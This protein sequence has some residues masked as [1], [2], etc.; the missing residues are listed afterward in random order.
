MLQQKKKMKP[1]AKVTTTEHYDANLNEIKRLSI[2][3]NLMNSRK[4]RRSNAYEA[5]PSK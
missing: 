3:L 1:Y 2:D 5:F 4:V